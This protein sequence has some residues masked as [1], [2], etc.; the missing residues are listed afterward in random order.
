MSIKIIKHPL[1]VIL[2]TAGIN[3]DAET[4]YAFEKA[5]AI[6]EVVHVNQFISHDN[7]FSNYKIIVIPGGFSY[8]DD[9]SSGRVMATELRS[10]FTDE[11]SE[12]I[13]KGR[14]IVGICN[15]FQV[16]TQTGLLPYGVMQ[17][18]K[19]SKV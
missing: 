4:R 19:N 15:G 1:A 17:S 5:G 13:Q 3:C 2:K 8:G 11:F 16:L 6:S 14:L 18:L 7:K 10:W 9:I 12:H